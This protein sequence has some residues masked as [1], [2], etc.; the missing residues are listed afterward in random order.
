MSITVTLLTIIDNYTMEPYKM[1]NVF[2]KL[3]AV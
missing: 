3:L 1:P 2:G